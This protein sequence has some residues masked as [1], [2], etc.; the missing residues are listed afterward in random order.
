M[1]AA[2]ANSDQKPGSGAESPLPV[3]K[4]SIGEATAGRVR[5]LQPSSCLVSVPSLRLNSPNYG[6]ADAPH[7]EKRQAFRYRVALLDGCG[8]D[9]KFALHLALF[10]AVVGDGETPQSC[11]AVGVL[12]VKP[13][14]FNLPP[15][16]W[17]LSAGYRFYFRLRVYLDSIHSQS[18]DCLPGETCSSDLSRLQFNLS[19][20]DQL[21]SALRN[22]IGRA[23]APGV[24]VPRRTSRVNHLPCVQ[25]FTRA[26][27]T[28]RTLEHVSIILCHSANRPC[29]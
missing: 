27:A 4:W 10:C 14:R 13:G 16:L 12:V 2:R 3:A 28:T 29:R 9:G 8:L 24:K 21:L 18:H 6:L 17:S 5:L 22:E 19:V 7:L 1:R 23:I 20:G 11:R 25:N 15:G 26:I